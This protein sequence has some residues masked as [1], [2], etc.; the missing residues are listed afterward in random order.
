MSAKSLIFVVTCARSSFT[1]RSVYAILEKKE[2]STV[3]LIME[4]GKQY[5]RIYWT[6]CSGFCVLQYY[7]FED[8]YVMAAINLGRT[9]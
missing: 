3:S 4:A 8:Y 5:S 2:V 6:K 1:Y 9:R 7:C